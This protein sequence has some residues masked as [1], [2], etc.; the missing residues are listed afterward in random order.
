MRCAEV[1]KLLNEEPQPGSV[2]LPEVEAH[3]EQCPDCRAIRQEL[4]GLR[5]VLRTLQPPALPEG[6]DLELRRRLV[7]ESKQQQRDAS[8]RASRWSLSRR[9]KVMALAASVLLVLSGV[10]IWR[11]LVPGST[12]EPVSYHRLHLAVSAAQI[13]E[14]ALFDIELPGGVELVPEAGVALRSAGT[15]RWKSDLL[16]GRNEID[17]PLVV[18]GTGVP[19]PIHARLTVEGRTFRSEVDLEASG[20]ASLRAPGEVK[21]VKVAW[22]LDERHVSDSRGVVR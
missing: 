18:R 13:H 4:V 9:E 19:G 21:V 11:A 7:A 12:Q 15:L 10:V 3:L 6:F 16:P 22:L 2:Q 20:R 1:Q 14:G 8:R 5:A 17:L